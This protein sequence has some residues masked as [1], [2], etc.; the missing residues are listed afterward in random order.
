MRRVF[1]LLPVPLRIMD[2]AYVNGT[3]EILLDSILDV[4]STE[5]FSK[6][7]AAYIVGGEIDS[8]KPSN[9]Q[10]GKWRCNA[11]QVLRHCRCTRKKKYK[12]KRKS[13]KNE[14]N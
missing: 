7:K 5:A 3:A 6:D 2:A 10:N 14:K 8:D 9:S 1:L 13:Q 12:Q 11:A 4:M